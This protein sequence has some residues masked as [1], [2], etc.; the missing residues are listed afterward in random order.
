MG[1]CFLSEGGEIAGSQ[2]KGVYF[3][4][5]SVQYFK[6]HIDAVLQLQIFHFLYLGT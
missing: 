6:K 3:M 4:C 1:L 2:V 5:A